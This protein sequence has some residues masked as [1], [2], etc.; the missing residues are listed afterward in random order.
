MKLLNNINIESFTSINFVSREAKEVWR[1]IIYDC[2]EL[3]QELELLSVAEDQRKCAWRTVAVEDVHMLT[4][5][6]LKLGLNTYPIQNI[7]SWGQGFTHKTQPAIKGKP[8]STYCIITKKI[9]YAQEYQAAFDKGDHKKQGELLGFPKCC[10]EFFIKNWPKYFDPVWQCAYNYL[11]IEAK[12]LILKINNKNI[13]M[14]VN[15]PKNSF[16][17][18]YSSCFSNPLLRYIGLRIGFHIPCSFNCDNSIKIAKERL[19][20]CKSQKDKDNSKLLILLLSMPMEWSLLHGIAKIKMPIFYLRTNSMPTEEKYII[21]LY[22]DFI[23]REAM[24]G[25]EFPFNFEEKT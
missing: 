21:R 17:F 15:H 3:V 25:S 7:G 6:C 23:P 24:K 16:Y 20:I 1:P 4:I 11:Q 12:K 10:T 18:N 9:E 5:K 2:A 22:G 8:M 14:D 19:S 13:L